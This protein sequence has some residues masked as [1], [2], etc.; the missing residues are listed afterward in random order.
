[1]SSEGSVTNWIGQLQAGDPAAAQRLW[2]RYFQRLVGLARKKL[3]DA[4]R[5]ASDE[6]D[7]ALS[8]FASF[9]RNATDGRFPQ[10]ADR[11]DLWR[12]LVTIT[13]RKAFHLR[14]DEGRQKRGG[15]EVVSLT[16]LFGSSSR[17]ESG[18]EELVDSEPTPAFAALVAEE[19]RRLLERLGDEQLRTIAL[20]KLEGDTND[21]IASKLGCVRATVQR[22]LCLIR[23]IWGQEAAL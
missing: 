14:R 13:A 12:L 20:C 19:S 8:A 2:E 18:L 22:K 11:D 7:V 6:E 1:M 21:E 16:Q 23:D 3:Q 17:A 9:C 5:G 10:L 15:G 4:P